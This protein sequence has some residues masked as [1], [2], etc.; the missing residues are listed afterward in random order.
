[1]RISRHLSRLTTHLYTRGARRGKRLL[2][3]TGTTSCLLAI[4]ISAGGHWAMLQSIAYTR[5]LLEFAEQ[6]SLG[7]AVKKTFDERYAC[8]LCPKIRDG[9]NHDHKKPLTLSEV[10]QP[11]F[12][13]QSN[14]LISFIRV[15]VAN[16]AFVPSRHIDF[17][18]APP[19]PPPR[20]A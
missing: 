3:L 17:P 13:P 15:V 16:L 11:E 1:M 19:K 20:V 5:M 6:D 2:H 9:F 7:T 18:N 8:S 14:A 4:F 10:Q 12:L